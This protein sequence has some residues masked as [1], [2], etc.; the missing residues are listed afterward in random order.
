M[1]NASSISQLVEVYEQ[2]KSEFDKKVKGLNDD[3]LSILT[4]LDGK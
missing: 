3:K 2:Q 1:F 4:S